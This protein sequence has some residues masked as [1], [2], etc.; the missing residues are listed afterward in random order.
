MES[1]LRPQPPAASIYEMLGL[2]AS[3]AA[4][5]D[6]PV[7]RR[8]FEAFKRFGRGGGVYP[9]VLRPL[10]RHVPD[11]DNAWSWAE[12]VD[13]PKFRARWL[14]DRREGT[15]RLGQI[16]YTPRKSATPEWIRQTSV[17]NQVDESLLGREFGREFN[18]LMAD[19][20]F[21]ANPWWISLSRRTAYG[22]RG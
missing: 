22:L 4:E 17:R 19:D 2:V 1:Q 14:G 5:S 16:E 10:E 13:V 20:R 3:A 9:N 8:Y 21:N 18:I 15:R 7:R 6:V 11:D 12:L